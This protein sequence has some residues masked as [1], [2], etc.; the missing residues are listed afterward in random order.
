V[1][2]RLLGFQGGKARNAE[3]VADTQWNAVAFAGHPYAGK[4]YGDDASIKGITADDLRAYCRRGFAKDRLKIVAAGDITA[5]ELGEF[6]DRVFGD[7]PANCDLAALPTA[8]PVAGGRLRVAEMDIP[9]SIVAFGMGAVPYDSPDFI[10]AYMLSHILGGHGVGSRLASE[11]RGKR[12]LA[13]SAWAW[14]ERHQHVAVLRGTVATRNDKVAQS[15]DIIRDEMQ[16]MSDGQLS[17]K[18]LDVARRYLMKSYVLRL[19]SNTS[20]AADLLGHAV[21][22]FG[23]DFIERRKAMIAAVTLDDLKRVARYMLDPENLIVSIAGTPAL[24]PAPARS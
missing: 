24:Q 16:K 2:R 3:L 4:G 15:L 12:G 20:I 13:Y 9:Q 21:Y 23:P 18:E 22:G 5:D 6:L 11:L 1:R 19:R 17:Q 14:L 7:L 10:P 8:N